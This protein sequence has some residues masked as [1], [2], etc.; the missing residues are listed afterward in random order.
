MLILAFLQKAVRTPGVR[1]KQ[2]ERLQAA[3]DLNTSR[4]LRPYLKIQNR[5]AGLDIWMLWMYTI[6][7]REIEKTEGK[8]LK[9]SVG[10]ATGMLVIWWVIAELAVRYGLSRVSTLNMYYLPIHGLVIGLVVGFVLMKTAGLTFGQVLVIGLG[11]AAGSF[12]GS[13]AMNYLLR[14]LNLVG[15]SL[16]LGIGEVIARFLPNPLV[17][18][19]LIGLFSGLLL[20]LVTALV[21]SRKGLLGEGKGL[22]ITLGWMVAWGLGSLLTQLLFNYMVSSMN[23]TFN[24]LLAMNAAIGLVISF[25]GGRVMF[26][27]IEES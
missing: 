11:W 8:V 1:A 27:S 21:L 24:L 15:G 12:A 4:P 14:G 25:I 26:K 16:D 19:S 17:R 6:S 2:P 13:Y 5:V 9:T 3:L 18:Y 22:K 23:M 10:R 7:G 20:G